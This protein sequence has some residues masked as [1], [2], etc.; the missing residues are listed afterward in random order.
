[1]YLNYGTWLTLYNV[2]KVPLGFLRHFQGMHCVEN[3]SFKSSGDICWPPWP[4][5]LLDDLSIGK[6][7]CDDIIILQYCGL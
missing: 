6:R 7:D 5:S 4:S 2:N 3:T 1:M